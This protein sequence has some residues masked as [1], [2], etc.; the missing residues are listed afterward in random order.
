LVDTCVIIEAF[1]TKCWKALCTH[2][3]VETVHCCV[4]E[5]CTGDPLQPMRT[6][7]PHDELR[8][9]LARVH[10]VDEMLLAQL[11]LECPQ[12]PALDDGERHLMAWLHAHPADAVLTAIS[13]ADRAAV[14]ATQ[15]LNMLD[16][17][18]SLQLLGQTAGVGRSQLNSL[19]PH[20][21]EDWLS[22]IRTQLLMGIL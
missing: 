14:R 8:E 16:R 13:T 3:S 11:A 22:S 1:R 17:V 21:Q 9:G 20:F 15:V 2:F 6:P 19:R 10:D 4:I 18:A 5:C 12:L 7:I